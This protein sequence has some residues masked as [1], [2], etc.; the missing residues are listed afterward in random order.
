MMSFLQGRRDIVRLVERIG[1]S[2]T[3]AAGPIH[4]FVRG[5]DL[6]AT[7]K[8]TVAASALLQAV[9]IKPSVGGRS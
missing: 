2:D 7:L 4:G 6:E 9:C 1:G 5:R 8:S 3:F